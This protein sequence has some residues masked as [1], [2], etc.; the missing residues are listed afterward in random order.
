MWPGP[1]FRVELITTS[2]R[3]RFYLVR[4]AFVAVLA[5]IVWLN[6]ESMHRYHG[7]ANKLDEDYTLREL[8][9]FAFQTFCYISIA[10]FFGVLF[11]TPALVA[12]V[13]SEEKQRKTLHY[14]L[15][16]RLSGA[17]IILG[18]LFSRL[19]HVA[20][21]LAL[22]LPVTS[23]LT[24]FGGLEPL[25]VVAVDV[26]LMSLAFFLGGL[27]ILVFDLRPPGARV[28]GPDDPPGTD[29]V[30]AAALRRLDAG[31]DP[32]ASLG[33]GPGMGQAGQ[34]VG[35]GDQPAVVPAGR[36]EGQAE[37]RMPCWSRSCG[38]SGSSSFTARRSRPWR[39]PGSGR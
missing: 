4:V 38:W 1:V 8:N 20:I 36:D 12:G 25:L 23:L 29:L 32:G 19:L 5:F 24:V 33:Q 39:S 22:A 13:V 16:S 26:V 31:V 27:S 14:L 9:Q 10:Q 30:P 15:S 18:K 2:R 21:F 35:L 6:Y 37:P 34:R 28:G 7:F 3:A 17:E 11:L